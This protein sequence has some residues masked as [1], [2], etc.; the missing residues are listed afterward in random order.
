VIQAASHVFSQYSRK[1]EASK[2]EAW[3]GIC[4][5][6]CYSAKTDKKR[7]RCKCRGVH[8]GKGQIHKLEEAKLTEFCEKQAL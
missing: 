5:S 6:G 7:C 3:K 2:Q 1:T 4:S 8:H